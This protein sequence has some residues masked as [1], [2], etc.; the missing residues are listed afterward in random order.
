MKQL[1]AL[2]AVVLLALSLLGCASRRTLGTTGLPYARIGASMPEPGGFKVK[3]HSVKDTLFED[4]RYEWRVAQVRYSEG[5]VYVE[6]DFYGS[7]KISRI[8]V[9]TPQVK[10]KN[11]LQTGKTVAELAAITSDW[12]ISPMPKYGLFDFYSRLFPR[13]HFV[14]DAPGVPT[15]RAWED[16]KLQDFPVQSQIVMI[17]VY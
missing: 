15:D 6:E 10:L 4:G 9:E 2:A 8:R 7:G 16:Y 13:T 5:V 14:V 11:G 3:G 1:S 17:T 12:Y